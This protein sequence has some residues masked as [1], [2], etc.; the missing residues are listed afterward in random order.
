[1][2]FLKDKLVE[3]HWFSSQE[4]AAAVLYA[5]YLRNVWLTD[6]T[7]VDPKSGFLGPMLLAESSIGSLLILFTKLTTRQSKVWKWSH[8]TRDLQKL[9]VISGRLSPTK[10][11]P[12]SCSAVL[13]SLKPH[14]CFVFEAKKGSKISANI[15]TCCILKGTIARGHFEGRWYYIT[16]PYF[17]P[18]VSKWYKSVASRWH[19]LKM[20]RVSK[21]QQLT[22][23]CHFLA[24][25]AHLVIKRTQAILNKS[26]VKDL[27]TKQSNKEHLVWQK[28]VQKEALLSSL[29]ELVG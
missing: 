7:V 18:I 13:S 26:F 20:S 3:F 16:F 25:T 10:F 8:S 5:K 14:F 4:A 12:A 6:A 1:M 23:L 29:F 19:E 17:L 11:M 15:C 2:H 22:L 9:L 28:L 21:T 24:H 27:V